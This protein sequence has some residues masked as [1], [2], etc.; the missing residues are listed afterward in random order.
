MVVTEYFLPLI[1]EWNRDEYRRPDSLHGV[2]P[3]GELIRRSDTLFVKMDDGWII[4]VGAEENINVIILG[5]PTPELVRKIFKKALNVTNSIRLTASTPA[6][7]V[8]YLS[9]LKEIGFRQEGR[10]RLGTKYNGQLTDL[11]ITGF[12]PT[13]KRGRRRKRRSRRA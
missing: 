1:L 13:D 2:F 7:A 4:F 11:I 6:S 10:I 9:L 12:V 3:L 5:E 8:N